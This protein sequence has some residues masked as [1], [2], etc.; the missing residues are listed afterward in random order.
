VSLE[1]LAREYLEG[2]ALALDP[3]RVASCLI[4][5]TRFYAGYGDIRSL[6]LSDDLPGATGASA[7][8]PDPLPDIQAGVPVKDIAVIDLDTTLTA[9]EWAIIRPL[10]VLYVELA[11]AEALEATR[12][13]GVDVYGRSVSEIRGDIRLMEDET[14]PAKSFV[15]PMIEVS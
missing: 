8:Y 13:L 4:E 1:Q 2:R 5:A 10:F 14:I 9:G 6:S 3:D 15:F 7:L 11:Q 12:G